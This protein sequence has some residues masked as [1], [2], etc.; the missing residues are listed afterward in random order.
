MTKNISSKVQLTL[1]PARPLSSKTKPVRWK[2]KTWGWGIPG[3]G[4]RRIKKA[5]KS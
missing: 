1:K 5:S 4:N 3:R 2:M